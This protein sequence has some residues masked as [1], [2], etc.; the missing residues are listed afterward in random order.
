MR[1]TFDFLLRHAIQAVLTHLLLTEAESAAS[2]SRLRDLI[3][4]A[5]EVVSEGS[6][7]PVL[8]FAGDFVVLCVSFS[9]FVR[10]AIDS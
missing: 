9:S 4:T 10:S 1:R 6:R 2:L 7:T 3:F 8:L 5:L